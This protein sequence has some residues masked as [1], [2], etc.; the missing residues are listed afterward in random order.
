MKG[1]T[2]WVI[3]R[4]PGIRKVITPRQE[5]SNP[6]DGPNEKSAGMNRVPV[7]AVKNTNIAVGQT[8]LPCF[9]YDSLNLKFMS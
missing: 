9:L 3:N 6:F 1:Q 8:D 4:Q 5:K 2:I 7:E